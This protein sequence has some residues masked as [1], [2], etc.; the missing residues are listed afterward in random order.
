MLLPACGIVAIDGG[1]RSEAGEGV[2]SFFVFALAA[3]ASGGADAGQ[4]DVAQERAG[5]VVDA[6]FGAGVFQ[7]S[8][9]K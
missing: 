6:D 3:E 1:W 9:E 5:E 7:V 8:Q 4:V 2:E